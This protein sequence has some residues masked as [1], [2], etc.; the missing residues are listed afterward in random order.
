MEHCKAA[1]HC[2]CSNTATAVER[3]RD[4]S[5]CPSSD[6]VLHMPSPTTWNH[7]EK[8]YITSLEA[9]QRSAVRCICGDYS[10]LSSVAAMRESLGWEILFG[11]R[12]LNAATMMFDGTNQQIHLSFPASTKFADS[13]TRSKHTF[14]VFSLKPKKWPK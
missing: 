11:C 13:R 6:L 10:R 5:G 14:K 7:F 4:H 3:N 9:V 12:Q 2:S 1:V 8:Q